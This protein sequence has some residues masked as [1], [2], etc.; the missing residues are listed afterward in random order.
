MARARMCGQTAVS[1]QSRLPRFRRAPSPPP[2]ARRRRAAGHSLRRRTVNCPRTMN[3]GRSSWNR[4]GGTAPHSR[5]FLP[6]STTST[7]SPTTE[8]GGGVPSC[9]RKR[10]AELGLN[11]NAFKERD[12]PVF[13]PGGPH[14][15]EN[16]KACVQTCCNSEISA[17]M[18]V[19]L[20]ASRT[21]I[22][23]WN[24]T[25]VVRYLRNGEDTP[26]RDEH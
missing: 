23:H 24:V 26:K 20:K 1:R 13:E 19:R 11:N 12:G 10:F 4:A 7:L 17:A 15:S 5:I 21:W 9:H 16:D 18:L 2:S 8:E 14:P 3:A 22:M 6:S 25:G